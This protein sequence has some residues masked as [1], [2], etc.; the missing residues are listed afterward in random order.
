ML[1][2]NPELDRRARCATA[3]TCAKRARGARHRRCPG[4]GAGK[5]QLELFEKTVEH[6]LRRPTFVTHY[7]GRG[8]AAA[9]ATTP[10]RS[11]PTASSSSSAGARS[12]T[13]SPSSTTRGPGR[14]LPR[15]GGAKDAGDEEAM[16]YDADYI[17]A[18]EY[19]MPPTAGSASASTGW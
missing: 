4:D 17:R 19:G 16:F 10:T 18:L 1:E 13:A 2:H 6:T 3:T 9:R 12:P 8:V 11:S 7:P 15:A 14:A 5:L